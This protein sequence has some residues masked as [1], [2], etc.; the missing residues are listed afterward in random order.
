[1]D[2]PYCGKAGMRDVRMVVPGRRD[3]SELRW[4]CEGC[5]RM[6]THTNV[7]KEGDLS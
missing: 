6:A 3:L 1:M 7:A 2:C 5:R 4:W